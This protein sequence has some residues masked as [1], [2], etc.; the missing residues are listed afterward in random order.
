MP[1]VRV[2]PPLPPIAP[3]KAVE[4][5]VRVSV[6]APRATLPEPDRV[7]IEAPDVVPEIS[8][9]PLSVTPLDEAIL[10]V[11]VSASVPPLIVVAPV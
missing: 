8:K 4:A 2:T 9:M 6:C 7:L 11:P 3:E 10:P 1:P 5:L